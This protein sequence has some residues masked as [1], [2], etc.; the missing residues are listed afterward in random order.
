M[1]ASVLPLRTAQKAVLVLIGIMGTLDSASGVSVLDSS[2]LSAQQCYSK[3]SGCT[4]F[5]GDVTG[6]LRYECFST[7]D[8][9]LSHCLDT[10][11]WSDSGL[12]IDPGTG[13]KPPDKRAQLSGLLMQ[14][15]MIL[16]DTDGDGT[17]SPKEIQSMKERVF[18]GVDATGG[19]T[20][21][22]Q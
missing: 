12:I 16:G 5:C 11:E 20:T 17:L 13:N 1:T 3:D 19:P 6:D 21:P 15:L 18:K 2:G 9:M 4:Q 10:G 7:C 14:M 8:R 22:K